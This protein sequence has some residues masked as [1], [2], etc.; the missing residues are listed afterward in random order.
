MS[1]KMSFKRVFNNYVGAA[2]GISLILLLMSG[3]AAQKIDYCQ[4]INSPGDYDLSRDIYN[5][6]N[7]AVSTCINITSNDVVF[8]G[9]NKF[10]TGNMAVPGTIGVYVHNDSKTVSNVTV[11]NLQVK[12][13]NY[14]IYYNN[15]RNGTIANNTVLNNS[16][17]SILFESSSNGTIEWNNVSLNERGIRVFSGHYNP[18]S[19]DTQ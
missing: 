8:D 12:D 10:I 17:F 16:E 4:V 3:V 11:K 14:G 6:G 2:I 9:G 18:S 7:S 5:V 15:T 19:P 13:L 1:G